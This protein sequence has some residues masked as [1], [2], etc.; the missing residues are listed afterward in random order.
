MFNLIREVLQCAKRNV[1]FWRIHQIVVAG[2]DMG[3]NDLRMAF[4]AESARLEE[5]F[6]KPNALIVDILPC[7]DV[8]DSVD[9]QI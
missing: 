1:L 4:G 2:S 9:D 3:Q 6:L 7:F 8:I 5:R